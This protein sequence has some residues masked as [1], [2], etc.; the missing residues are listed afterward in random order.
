MSVASDVQPLKHPDKFFIGGEW[1]EPS[2]S[3]TI[4]GFARP[5]PDTEIS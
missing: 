3:S 1:V 2:S 5:F 4:D